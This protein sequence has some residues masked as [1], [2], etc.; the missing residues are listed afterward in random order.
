VSLVANRFGV[1]SPVRPK[2][3]LVTPNPI[4]GEGLYGYQLRV[5]EANSYSGVSDVLRASGY[6]VGGSMRCLPD[7][8]KLAKVLRGKDLSLVSYSGLY[9]DIYGPNGRGTN[10]AY[11]RILD[12]KNPSVCPICLKEN[13]VLLKFWDLKMAIACPKHECLL[14]THCKHCNEQLKWDRPGVNQCGCGVLLSDLP[15][16]SA[17]KEMVT[18]MNVLSS[19]VMKSSFHTGKNLSNFPELN[20]K[21]LTIRRITNLHFIFNKFHQENDKTWRSGTEFFALTLSQWPRNYHSLLDKIGVSLTQGRT[22][23]AGFLSQFVRFN[24]S[25]FKGGKIK[26]VE[27]FYE[28]FLHFGARVWSK[29]TLPPK[30]LRR[31]GYGITARFVTLH[32]AAKEWNVRYTK[33]KRWCDQGLIDFKIVDTNWGKSYIVDL[34]S[35]NVK[36]DIIGR[37]MNAR[38]AAR[39]LSLPTK[40]IEEF[41]KY[42]VF[43]QEHQPLN[44]RGFHEEDLRA[45][46]LQFLNISRK[47]RIDK[48]STNSLSIGEIYTKVRFYGREAR[49]CFF[50]KV[51]NGGISPIG[52]TGNSICSII[53]SED[54]VRD[55]VRAYH[56]EGDKGSLS[57]TKVGS[58][59]GCYSHGVSAMLM[60][61]YLF[62][63]KIANGSPCISNESLRIFTLNY[64]LLSSLAKKFKLSI[65][66]MKSICKFNNIPYQ[67]VNGRS[68]YLYL[69]E[70]Q[71]LKKL[72]QILQNCLESSLED[73]R[74]KELR[75]YLSGLATADNQLTVNCNLV[76]IERVASV[77]ATKVNTFKRSERLMTE[78]SIF[79]A[80]YCSNEYKKKPNT[81]KVLAKYFNDLKLSGE[82]P[83]LNT[84]G[85]L[86][87]AE[88]ARICNV[89]RQAFYR[90]KGVETILTQFGLNT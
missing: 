67:I 19:I 89:P 78:I 31:T 42:G 4:N 32:Q 14:V 56:E 34:E 69:I 17:S 15:V 48:E 60:S 41:R 47:I 28:E 53:F 77:C 16:E 30:L 20:T 13:K 26:G 35:P 54:V 27:C 55:F 10:R 38:D 43:Q 61:G 86:N 85:S 63:E 29:G 83:P 50:R 71:Y 73:M 8:E 11:N 40:M 2:H 74:V 5:S 81:S 75:R 84:N 33:V 88:I 9:E 51:L 25:M 45:L 52:R 37:I 57:L 21:F 6:K 87:K 68:S 64:T 44:N 18:L 62:S 90:N 39:F 1:P 49:A 70:N 79:R 36:E 12:L 3:L 76:S 22:S 58:I 72:E 7:T 80:E 46:E 23:R 59:L 24:R 82:S 66:Y 65:E